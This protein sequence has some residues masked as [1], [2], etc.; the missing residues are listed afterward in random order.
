MPRT[1]GSL[2]GNRYVVQRQIGGGGGG[3]V[4]LA[5]DPYM[6]Q[7]VVVKLLSLEGLPPGNPWLEAQALSNLA[8]EHI[9]RIWNAEIDAGQPY[10]VTEVAHHGTMS[11]LIAASAGCGLEVDEV[12]TFVRDACLGID[13]AHRARLVHNDIKPENL[14]LNAERECL[15]GDF[16]GASLIPA[17]ASAGVPHV[18]TPQIA[19]PEMAAAWGTPTS[20]VR[21]DVYSLGVTAYWGLVGELPYAF[22]AGT[23]FLE[24]LAFVAANPL[25]RLRDRAPHIPKPVADTIERAMSRDP[26]SRFENALDFADK[27]GGRSA[28]SRRWKQSNPH[29]GHLRCWRGEPRGGGSTYLMCLEQGS[30]ANRVSIT[31]RREKSG[32]RITA[33]CRTDIPAAS[34]PTAI[35]G[36]IKKLA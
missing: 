19:A 28:P 6:N 25:P 35:R 32:N 26:S 16:G 11:D 23:S 7:M 14:F 3:E 36:L 8:D 10:I 24:R 4:Y 22:P 29:A 5:R 20:T 34:W 2:I 33:G 30:R 17:G 15:V 12:V 18:T 9:L 31:T 1:P 27:L 13:R 21:S